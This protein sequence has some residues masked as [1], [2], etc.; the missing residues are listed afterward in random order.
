MV[1]SEW[2]WL[3][4]LLLFQAKM[5]FKHVNHPRAGTPN[6]HDWME[7]STNWR[8]I[9]YWTWWFFQCHVRCQGRNLHHTNPATCHWMG[10]CTGK[11]T[12]WV[13]EKEDYRIRWDDGRLYRIFRQTVRTQVGFIP[14]K[15]VYLPLNYS[16]WTFDYF[17]NFLFILQY[18]ELSL[19]I[20][21]VYF[22]RKLGFKIEVHQTGLIY[23][24]RNFIFKCYLH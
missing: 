18:H 21:A 6:Q 1:G 14:R 4:I 22:V 20:F 24:L 16:M 11:N 13:T 5:R 23:I 12:T 2:P 19:H 9:S 3:G 8:C 7:K 10:S 17:W 15:S